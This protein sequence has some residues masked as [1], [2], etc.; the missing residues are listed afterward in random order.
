LLSIAVTA[1]A[2]EGLPLDQSLPGHWASTDRQFV[3]FRPDKTFRMYPKCGR[4][5]DEWKQ[6]GTPFLPATWD[7]VD[8]N[9]LKLTVSLQDQ[10]RTIDSTVVLAGDELRLVD[11][12]GRT[13]VNRRYVGAWPPVC[14]ANPSR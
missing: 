2:Q 3:E 9:H 1:A 7:I 5:A 10:S 8:G 13:T 6:R 4:E 11:G 12:Q 14:P